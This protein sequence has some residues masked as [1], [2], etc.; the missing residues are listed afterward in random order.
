ML[1]IGKQKEKEFAAFFSNVSESTR[2]QDIN[3]HWDLNVRYDV[4]M[5]NCFSPTS[6][7]K[8]CSSPVISVFRR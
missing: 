8:K 3:E 2:D 7:I 1:K 5:L 6:M 4:K